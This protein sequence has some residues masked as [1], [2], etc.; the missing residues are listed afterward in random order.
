MLKKTI[1]LWQEH[2]YQY[3]MAQ[4]FVPNLHAYLHED[5]VAGG[6]PSMIVVPGGAYTVISPSEGESVALKFYEFGYNTFVLTYTVNPL[7]DAPLHDQPMKDLSRA[8][9]ILRANYEALNLNC[10]KLIIS[11]FSAG[12]HLCGSLC[13]HHQEIQDVNDVYHQISNRPNAVILAYPVITTG[14]FS[15]Q[16]SI[17]SLVGSSGSV[18][19]LIYYSLEKQVTENMPPCFIWHTANDETV[20]IENSL[21]FVQALR[22][23]GVLFAYHVFSEGKHGL[24][25]AEPLTAEALQAGDYVREQTKLVM[26][27]LKKGRITVSEDTVNRLTYYESKG[28]PSYIPNPDVAVWTNLAQNW[29]QSFIF[30][31]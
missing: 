16:P 27:A 6:R 12:G 29:L 24:S 15:N 28:L 5:K 23:T 14:E 30:T 9:R 11:G 4:G 18:E 8:V 2:E 1:N 10:D 7:S 3:S 17:N 25:T 22:K 26:N 19:E 21:L 13:V 31:N 20:P